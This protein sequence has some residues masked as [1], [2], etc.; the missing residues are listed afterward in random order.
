MLGEMRATT[1]LGA[2]L[3]VLFL[4]MSMTADAQN[5]PSLPPVVP[6]EPA[7]GSTAESERR[8]RERNES[9]E[10]TVGAQ[11]RQID[12]LR[13]QLA[14]RQAELE[15]LTQLVS[16]LESLR[17]D[18]AA[19]EAMA[20]EQQEQEEVLRH[21]ATERQQRAIELLHQVEARLALGDGEVDDTLAEAA[22]LL[23]GEAQRQ[24]ERARGA[25]GESDASTA[26][27]AVRVALRLS[28]AAY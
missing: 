10:A 14:D 20:A 9:L 7:A 22:G 4:A 11:Q 5:G 26:R 24:V 18:L 16:G 12:E 19:R 13:R 23:Y 28:G 25:L 3:L 27:E 1:F 15:K 2:L 6:I 8:W 21:E 17:E